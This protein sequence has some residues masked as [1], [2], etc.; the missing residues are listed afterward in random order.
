MF[1]ATS[2]TVKF[3]A[4]STPE[5]R[6]SAMA[7]DRSL[8][9]FWTLVERLQAA[10]DQHRPIHQVEETIFRQLL[11]MG[12]SLLQAF[13]AHSGEGDA[14]P[15]LTVPGDR[16]S[17]PPQVLPRLETLRSRPYL[18]IFGETTIAR[19]GYG[20]DRVEAAPLDARLHLP[21]RQYSY[22]FQQWLGAFVI[23]DA[24]AEAIKKLQTILGLGLSVKAS[25][26][27][28]REQAS[29]VEPFQ[30]HLPTPEPTEEGP[31]LVVTADCKGVPLVRSALGP[32][33]AGEEAETSRLPAAANHRRGK[34]EK[35]NK[36]RMAAVGAV[37]TIDQFP[38]TADEVI[39]EVMREKAAKRRPR[40]VHKRVRAELLV[41]KVALFL[42]LADEVI[43]RNPAGTKPLVFLSDGERA[44]HDRQGEYLPDDVICILDLFHVMERLWK[45]AWCFFDEATQKR[46]AHEWVEE[47]LRMLLEGKVRYVI[48][49][50]RQMMTKRDL[51]GTRRKTIRDVTG[52]FDRNRAR[53]KYDEYLAAGHPIGSGVAEGAC[54]HL[55][56]DRLERAGMRW[57]PSGAQ[58]MLDLRSTYLNGEWETFWAYHVEQEDDRL[59]GNLRQIG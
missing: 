5:Q 24:H 45:A 40:P 43:R 25:E 52:Y 12:L 56:K 36:K 4:F 51:K 17:D 18:S 58:A 55:V 29:D 19:V 14:G 22:L 20:H 27:L 28:N 39:D 53:M 34:G 7:I 23:D 26:D 31:I 59:Y 35:A 57:V 49:G 1:A 42:W 50:L 30:N 44:L 10:A 38:R 37:Y 54:R 48:S 16:P 9:L 3:E 47:H 46:E 41:G 8:T 13:L 32:E 11:A 21:R 2:T 15:T 6:A 33:A